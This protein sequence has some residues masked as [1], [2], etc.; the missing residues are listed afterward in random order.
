MRELPNLVKNDHSKRE[1]FKINQISD[2]LPKN[3]TADADGKEYDERHKDKLWGEHNKTLMLRHVASA[4]NFHTS[5]VERET[6]LHLL[7]VALDKLQHEDMD[8]TAVDVFEYKTAMKL[9]QQIQKVAKD[10]EHEFYNLDKEKD[11]LKTKK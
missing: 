11:K 2:S 8:A 10:L 5:K 4:R 1:L 6:P 3:M 9:T 7:Q